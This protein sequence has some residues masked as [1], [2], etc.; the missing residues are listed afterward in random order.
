V[1]DEGESSEGRGSGGGGRNHRLGLATTAASSDQSPARERVMW[2]GEG[3]RVLR[4]EWGVEWC[5]EWMPGR[6]RFIAS[7]RGIGSRTGRRC[8]RCYNG[9]G[10]WARMGNCSAGHCERHGGR[11]TEGEGLGRSGACSCPA[12]IDGCRRRSCLRGSW[13]SGAYVGERR[14][15]GVVSVD[16]ARPCSSVRMGVAVHWMQGMGTL[17]SRRFAPRLL[18]GLARSRSGEQGKGGRHG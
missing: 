2:K 9:G 11:G 6:S 13:C 10:T 15:Q 4:E 12:D 3:S 7:E 18:P 8:R 16:G 1:E 14:G 17:W 5:E